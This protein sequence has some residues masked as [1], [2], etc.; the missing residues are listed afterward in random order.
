[1]FHLFGHSDLDG[2][3]SMALFQ[4][5]YPDARINICTYSRDIKGL[6]LLQP[7]DTIVIVDF[8]FPLDLMKDLSEKYRLIWIDHHRDVYETYAKAGFNPE[9]IRSDQDAACVLT[10]RY[11]YGNKPIPQSILDMGNYDMWRL[12]SDVIAINYAMSMLDLRPYANNKELWGKIL[13]DDP[14]IMKG[15]LTKGHE[16][17]E[18]V[19]LLNT[20]QMSDT[21]YTGEFHGKK[22]M[23]TN[24]KSGSSLIFESIKEPCDVKITYG[25]SS[26]L[27]TW[28][29]TIYKENPAVDVSEIARSYSGNGHD[30]AAGWTS[31]LINVPLNK[32]DDPLPTVFPVDLFNPIFS[33]CEVSQ[34]AK[35]YLNKEFKSAFMTRGFLTTIGT[36]KCFAMNYNMNSSDLFSSGLDVRDSEFGITFVW[37][38]YGYYRVI[39]RQ[40]KPVVDWS[41]IV[42]AFPHS[43]MVGNTLWA[44]TKDLPFHLNKRPSLTY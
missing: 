9:G 22:A 7:G 1:M 28:K 35:A 14:T 2:Y 25:W 37:I 29:Y 10:W 31:S 19:E 38:K 23:I 42:K 16:L 13:T 32:T 36:H 40:L 21:T 4:Q 6:D 41:E 11:L 8:S 15:L 43:Q 5:K 39:I 18:F 24:A 33:F 27:N 12:T 30:G 26:S 44:Y 20:I 34:L 17:R 3:S